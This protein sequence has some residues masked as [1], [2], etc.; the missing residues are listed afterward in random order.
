[1][2]ASKLRLPDSMDPRN[3][4]A[5]RYRLL[6]RELLA[7]DAYRKGNEAAKDGR[8]KK[9]REY[10]NRALKYR[11]N[12]REAKAA[13]KKVGS[14]MGEAK[15]GSSQKLYKQGLEAFLAGDQELESGAPSS[16]DPGFRERLRLP[17]V[18]IAGQYRQT[19]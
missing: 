18:D 5:K 16:S 10:F 4:E 19:G 7:K 9:A 11:P 8:W 2:R 15:K 12:M 1:M 6:C 13:L 17:C 14:Q 3:K